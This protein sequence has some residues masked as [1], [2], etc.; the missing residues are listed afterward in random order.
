VIRLGFYTLG[1]SD[2]RSEY[3]TSYSTIAFVLMVYEFTI[4][5]VIIF[6]TPPIPLV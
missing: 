6:V 1:A 5:M 2:G 4:I 3:S